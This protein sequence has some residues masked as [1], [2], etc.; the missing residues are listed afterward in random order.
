[1]SEAETL[2]DSPTA[3]SRAAI[4]SDQALAERSLSKAAAWHHRFLRNRSAFLGLLILL[5]MISVALLAPVLAP[6][7]PDKV[8]ARAILQPASRDHLLGTDNL[9]RDLLS[10]LIWGAR[11]SLGT[12]IIAGVAISMIGTTI[13]LIAGFSRGWLDDLLMRIV[14]VLLA[15]PGIVVALAVVGLTGPGLV[16]VMLAIIA[17]WWVDYARLMRATTLRVR[18]EEFVTAARCLGAS[19]RVIM[20]RHVL[21]NVLPSSIVLASLNIGSLLLA[22]AG[23]SFL[24]FG[25]QP[26]TPEWGTMLENGR[27]FFQR[28]PAL[29]IYP[30]IA[31]TL[32]AVAFNLIGDG[33]RDALDP[34]LRH[35]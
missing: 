21:P 3:A 17:I 12:S 11:W 18:E 8:N 10:R 26:P 23:L 19:Q 16:Q 13:G 2:S 9:G 4:A 24:G 33:V 30:G 14:D 28:A 1:M 6:Y 20:R 22:L 7:P 32:A 5:S 29:M 27:P 35:E 34:H 25:A 15:L 31:I